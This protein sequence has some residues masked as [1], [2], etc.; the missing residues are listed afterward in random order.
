[1]WPCR[2]LPPWQSGVS[3]PDTFALVEAAG[4]LGESDESTEDGRRTNHRGARQD[5]AARSRQASCRLFAGAKVWV[6]AAG[7]RARP[8]RLPLRLA[9]LSTAAPRRPQQTA[10]LP[11]GNPLRFVAAGSSHEGELGRSL[12]AFS[13]DA[14][15]EIVSQVRDG[16]DDGGRVCS[17]LTLETNERSI[18]TVVI[19][20]S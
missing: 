12:H 15:T 19:G 5:T 14:Q 20:S 16:R 3:H 17:S 13:D 6:S 2:V 11:E 9:R 4:K 7:T 8:L 10:V 18:L 1:M